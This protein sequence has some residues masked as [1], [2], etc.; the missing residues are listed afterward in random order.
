MADVS[1]D[2][3][4]PVIIWYP[5][6]HLKIQQ[7]RNEKFYF[8]FFIIVYQQKNINKLGFTTASDSNSSNVN[9]QS[10]KMYKPS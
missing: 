10:T 6:I 8:Y 9:Q 5:I 2:S 7:Q 3:I 4:I 1:M